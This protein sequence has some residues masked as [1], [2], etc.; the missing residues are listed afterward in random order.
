[1]L[2]FEK[3]FPFF[4]SVGLPNFCKTLHLLVYCTLF[5]YFF[6]IFQ[7]NQ[8]TFFCYFVIC[9]QTQIFLSRFSVKIS[10][11]TNVLCVFH[12]NLVFVSFV[13]FALSVPC[14]KAFMFHKICSVGGDYRLHAPC[15]TVFYTW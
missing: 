12:Q 1:M 9:V 2:K 13:K 7:R 6:R 5:S 3:L 15:H 11:T 10:G 14:R 4:C 8:N